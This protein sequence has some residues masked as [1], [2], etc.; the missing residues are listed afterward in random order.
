MPTSLLDTGA[1]LRNL[2][3]T[4]CIQTRSALSWL[5]TCFKSEMLAQY[6]MRAHLLSHAPSK[7]SKRVA[8]ISHMRILDFA[9][10]F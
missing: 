6:I 2:E 10:L 7:S 3:V 8:S 9:N 5:H 1:L 4:H